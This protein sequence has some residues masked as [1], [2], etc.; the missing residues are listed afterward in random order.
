MDKVLVVKAAPRFNSLGEPM[1][2]NA[3]REGGRGPYG[4]TGFERFGNLV[5]VVGGSLA[6]LAGRHRSAG[7]LVQ[8]LIRGGESGAALGGR[9][10]RGLSGRRG[11]ARANLQEARRQEDARLA[12]E[13]ID[14][15]G[16]T[17]SSEARHLGGSIPFFNRASDRE[18]ADRR[19]DYLRRQ[20]ENDRLAAQQA[21]E[22]RE[23]EI[24]RAKR[25][26][27]EFGEQDLRDRDAGA[28][29]REVVGATYGATP[30][31]F[32][33][34]VNMARQANQRQGGASVRFD[35]TQGGTVAVRADG[36]A[37]GPSVVAVQ[38]TASMPAPAG[39]AGA[40]IK[41]IEEVGEQEAVQT[42]TD[43]SG[44]YGKRLALPA[45]QEEEEEEEENEMSSGT[46][47]V[48]NSM[49]PPV[50]GTLDAI[51]ARES[52]GGN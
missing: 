19:R 43:H 40:E 27:T 2:L 44:D 16:G 21:R 4:K 35:P 37:I 17:R 51:Q 15:F 50:P 25:R 39:G 41:Q 52:A 48:V 38:N 5:G 32:Y 23:E 8:S 1:P 12:A 3:P 26:G 20:A 49:R 11:R 24:A 30:E 31:E 6:A 7:D 9:F 28:S 34:R 36:S 18:I 22:A 46:V 47:A 45:P 42:G 29:M 10:G 14:Q 33:E 13:H